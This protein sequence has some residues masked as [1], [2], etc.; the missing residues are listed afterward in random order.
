M[1]DQSSAARYREIRSKLGL[2]Q[3]QLAKHLRIVPATI[4]A[5]ERGLADP[6]MDTAR[7][8]AELGGVSLEWVLNGREPS[9]NRMK[10]GGG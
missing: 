5:R 2:S 6:R 4:S 8:L 10:G 1:P 3:G 7:E 9:G